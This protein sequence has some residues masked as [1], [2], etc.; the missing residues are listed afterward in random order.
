[1]DASFKCTSRDAESAFYRLPSVIFAKMKHQ[2]H[3]R[4]AVLEVD[5]QPIRRQELD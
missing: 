4:G 5:V 1:M 2:L 3:W